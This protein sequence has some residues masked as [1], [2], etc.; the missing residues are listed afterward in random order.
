MPLTRT[1]DA[2]FPEAVSLGAK[3]HAMSP[4]RHEA[5]DAEAVRAFLQ[6]M[7]DNP[8]GYFVCTGKGLIGG[9]LIPLWFSPHVKLAVEMFWYSEEIGE[10]KKLREGFEQWANDRGAKHIQFSALADKNEDKLRR[11]MARSGYDAIEVGFRKT[12]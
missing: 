10:G 9:I 11:I 4:W 3:F 12:L 1:F 6:S 2:A 5:Y 8:D 7:I